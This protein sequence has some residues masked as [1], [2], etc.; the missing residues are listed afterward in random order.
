[1]STVSKTN[2]KE[3][4]ADLRNRL[5]ELEETLR[6]IRHGE[7]D[8]VVVSGSEG[9]RVFTLSG[10]EHPYRV[11]VES[12]NEGAATLSSDGILLYAN[13]RFAEMLSMP[14]ERLIGHSLQKLVTVA[15]DCCLADILHDAV[16][17]PQKIECTF[18][19]KNGDFLPASLSFSPLK[20]E[21]VEAISLIITDLSEQKGRELELA[22]INETLAQEV[23]Q[24]MCAEEAL[25]RDE[26]SLRQLS[27]RLLQLQDEER[28]RIARDLHDTTGQKV[29]G[30]TLELNLATQHSESFS[31]SVRRALAN[32][33]SLA[34]QISSEIRTLSY[35]LHPPLLDEIG[36][37]SA[38]RWFVDG[39]VRRSNIQVEVLAPAR[40][41]RMPQE[42]EL[43]LFRLLQES[44][45]NVHRH[46]GSPTAEVVFEVADDQITL[47]VK[48]KGA[49]QDHGF[50][51]KD[52]IGEMMGVGIRG[53]RERVR[54]LGGQLDLI[55]SDGGTTMR[56]RLPLRHAN[57][58][59]ESVAGP[60]IQSA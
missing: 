15:G 34:D 59:P 45:T 18:E 13:T 17:S 39:F 51:G 57:Y 27:G 50:D 19:L 10:A 25:R 28:R 7:V 47:E 23:E 33:I 58:G 60:E 46:S 41:E 48:D 31:P 30:L 43:T 54:Q 14:L 52:R 5:Q 53:M 20:G 49:K 3:D 56:A 12:M 1:M 4:P 36:L 42:M 29:V 8:A 32:C 55:S 2:F 9:D 38:T 37:L 35:V 6:A 40:L 26:E 44:L 24:R 11:L 16:S 22:R 21:E